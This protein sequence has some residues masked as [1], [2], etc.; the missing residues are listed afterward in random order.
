MPQLSRVSYTAPSLNALSKMTKA[1]QETV[2]TQEKQ[3]N[4]KV[5]ILFFFLRNVFCKKTKLT[6]KKEMFIIQYK[7]VA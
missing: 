4:Y 2:G 6:L 3:R 5:G 1:A 7:I